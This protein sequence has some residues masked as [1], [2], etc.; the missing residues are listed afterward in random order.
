M[1]N[2][3]KW[4]TK[5][6]TADFTSQDIPDDMVTCNIVKTRW[7]NQYDQY[8]NFLSQIS[9][10]ESPQ[11]SLHS[12]IY[13]ALWEHLSFDEKYRMDTILRLYNNDHLAVLL[14]ILNFMSYIVNSNERSS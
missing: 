1:I 3:K 2:F 4:A 9:R 13:N 5:S 12:F 14:A 8:Y 10:S 7:D 6:N 11:T